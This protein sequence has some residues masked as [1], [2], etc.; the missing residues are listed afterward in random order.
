MRIFSILFLLMGSIAFGQPLKLTI[1]SINS[2]EGDEKERIFTVKYNLTNTTNDTLNFFFYPKDVSPSTGGSLTKEMYYKIYENNTFIEIGAAFNQFA[3][4]KVDFNFNSEMTQIQKD[5]VMIVFMA[6]KLEVDPARLLKIYKEEG[7]LGLMDPSKDYIQKISNRIKNYY[8]TLAP[9][10]LE[11]FEA[12]F[13]WNKSR[14]YYNEPNEFYLDENAKHY[15]ELTLVALKEEFKDKVDADL[16]E[17]IMKQPN[18][19]KGVFVSN[20]VEIDF[21]SK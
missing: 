2:K 8:H 7:A 5:S 6:E 16:F 20:R 10:Q 9:K 11:H 15:F 17:K 4:Q 14:Y 12:T 18:F 21:N 19:I 3:K 13:S 1:D